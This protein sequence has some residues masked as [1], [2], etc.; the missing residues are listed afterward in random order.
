MESLKG[1]INKSKAGTEVE[2]RH[3]R[4]EEMRVESM[5]KCTRVCCLCSAVLLCV[6]Q[7]R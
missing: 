4:C 1:L 6:Q 7:L 5:N 2:Q 3:E